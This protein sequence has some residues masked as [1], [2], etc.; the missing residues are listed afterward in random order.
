MIRH[1]LLKLRR[2]KAVE[3]HQAQSHP[4]YCGRPYSAV[5]SI[6]ID[7]FEFIIHEFLVL[8]GIICFLDVFVTFFT[9]EIEPDTASLTPKP[10]FPRWILPGL[11]LQLAV[12]PQMESTSVVVTKVHCHL[13]EQTTELTQT[14]DVYLSFF[15]HYQE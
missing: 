5:Q 12:N 11:V 9:G 8:V 13:G 14:D 4:W 6:Y 7:T 3:K 10:F 15:R 2:K 1:V